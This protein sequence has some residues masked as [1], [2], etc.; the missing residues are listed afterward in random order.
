M[1]QGYAV[2]LS[3]RGIANL[4]TEPPWHYA[5]VVVGAEFWT[6]PADRYQRARLPRGAR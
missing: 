1:L 3:P 4:V 5:G 6:H 2:P